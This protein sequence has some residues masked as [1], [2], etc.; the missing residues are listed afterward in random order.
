MAPKA[1]KPEHTGTLLLRR[2]RRERFVALYPDK[3]LNCETHVAQYDNPDAQERYSF[4]CPLGVRAI[5]PSPSPIVARETGRLL[6][7]YDKDHARE[8]GQLQ[9]QRLCKYGYHPLVS[10]IAWRTIAAVMRES[11]GSLR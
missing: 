3:E 5:P 10:M 8:S 6:S 9:K 7:I 2:F 11:G 4:H 1:Q